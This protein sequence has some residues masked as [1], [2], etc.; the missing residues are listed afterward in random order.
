MKYKRRKFIAGECLHVYQRTIGGVN[1]FYD[2][3]D[4]LVFYTIFSS[5]SK[6]Y[7]LSI[8]LSDNFL[9][10]R[11]SCAYDKY[12]FF[13]L[14]LLISFKIDRIRGGHSLG[15]T[16]SENGYSSSAYAR[17]FHL[18]SDASVHNDFSTGLFPIYTIVERIFL[19]PFF[20]ALP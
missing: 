3:V 9:N 2:R 10:I 11:L 1:I 20:G 19:L 12:E 6:L 7:D 5:I 15:D 14:F 8:S 16:L 17:K 13:S 18:Y 4:Y